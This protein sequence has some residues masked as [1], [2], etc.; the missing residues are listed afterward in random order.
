MTARS[1]AIR[2]AAV[3]HAEVLALE[4]QVERAHRGLADRK[5]VEQA[6]GLLM[7]AHELSEE[8]PFARIERTAR[9]RNLRLADVAKRIVQQRDLLAGRRVRQERV[10]PGEQQ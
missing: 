7:D 4:A 5:L 1:T 2:V 8:E 6:E 3:R 10:G 9:N